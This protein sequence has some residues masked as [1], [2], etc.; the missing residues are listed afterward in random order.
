MG[1]LSSMGLMEQGVPQLLF[2]NVDTSHD[3]AEGSQSL[4]NE[5]ELE[6]LEK[7][8]P[9]PNISIQFNFLKLLIYCYRVLERVP[10]SMTKDVMIICLYKEQKRRS[11]ALLKF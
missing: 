2:V 11:K 5:G 8:G 7:Y 10:C 3:R 4:F 1:V 6:E 9:F